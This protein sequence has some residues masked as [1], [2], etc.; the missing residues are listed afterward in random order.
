VVNYS[1]RFGLK[2]D[3]IPNLKIHSLLLFLSENKIN[4]QTFERDLVLNS[5]G[6]RS[7]SWHTMVQGKNLKIFP[8]S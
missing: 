6:G 3:A 4:L 1:A 2:D 7:I 5:N 8:D